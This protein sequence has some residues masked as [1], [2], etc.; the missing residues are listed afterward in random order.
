MAIQDHTL[1][2]N[3]AKIKITNNAGNKFTNYGEYL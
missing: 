2:V 1:T 3:N